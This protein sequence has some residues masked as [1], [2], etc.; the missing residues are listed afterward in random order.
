MRYGNRAVLLLACSVPNLSFDSR[1]V[2]HYYILRRK[3]YTN[4][5][6]HFARQ[7]ILNIATNQTGFADEDIS[8]QDNLTSLVNYNSYFCKDVRGFVPF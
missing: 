1:T 7:L 5:R 3:L 8:N 2:L 6:L 4:R